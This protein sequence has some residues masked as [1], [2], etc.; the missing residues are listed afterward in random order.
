MNWK[1]VKGYWCWFLGWD[2]NIYRWNKRGWVIEGSVV[3][4]SARQGSELWNRFMIYCSKQTCSP[5]QTQSTLNSTPLQIITFPTK[6]FSC[7]LS[8]HDGG[9]PGEL[10]EYTHTHLLLYTAV[11]YKYVMLVSYKHYHI[12]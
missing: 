5:L 12:K 11:C 10:H 2:K 6:A 4:F 3:Q 9:R 8:C 1:I 7:T